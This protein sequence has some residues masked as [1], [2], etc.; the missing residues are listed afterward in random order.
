[1]EIDKKLCTGCG[2]CAR[3]C[4]VKAIDF[5]REVKVP[6]FV[7]DGAEICIH[8]QH[9]V[10]VCPSGALSID[11][12]KAENCPPNGALPE[13]E[14]MENLIHQ[15]RSIRRFSGEELPPETLEKLKNILHWTPTGC[16]NHG[17]QFFIAGKK[18]IADVF[19]IQ[20]TVRNLIG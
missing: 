17:L 19:G 1:M 20:R 5:D 13:V 9:C 2:K 6:R 16:N 8:C 7:D 3:D 15:R 12:V 18:E 4:M 14:K 10:A 11:G